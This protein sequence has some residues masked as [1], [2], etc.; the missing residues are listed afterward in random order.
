MDF[1]LYFMLIF[2]SL[3]NNSSLVLGKVKLKEWGYNG[4]AWNI[5][6][7]AVYNIINIVI[8]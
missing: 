1:V 4:A 7:Y 3:S 5:V 2:S 6:R 8:L